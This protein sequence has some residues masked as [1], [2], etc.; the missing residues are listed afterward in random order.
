MVD[1]GGNTCSASVLESGD[2][3]FEVLA[4]HSNEYLGGKDFDQKIVDWLVSEVQHREGI[5]LS[6]DNL[7][8]QQL[9]QIAETAKIELSSV[10][11]TW[12]SLPLLN[13][14]SGWKHIELT[15]TRAEF[16][17]R[18]S[19][20]LKRC[21]LCIEKAMKGLLGRLPLYYSLITR[22]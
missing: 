4:T 2:G 15:L 6:Q 11:E 10:N 19:D 12:I 3:I 21:R 13:T 1:L 5:D 22:D 9:A 17:A 8:M 7:A 18:C 14:Q 20:L 16:E